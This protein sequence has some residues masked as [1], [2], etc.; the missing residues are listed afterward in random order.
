MGAADVSQECGWEGEEREVL[1]GTGT[2]SSESLIIY[3][4]LNTGEM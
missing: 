4:Y 3:I 2:E 1:A